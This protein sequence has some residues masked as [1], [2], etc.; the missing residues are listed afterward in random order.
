MILEFISTA[1]ETQPGLVELFLDLSS[2]EDQVSFLVTSYEKQT[3]NEIIKT[4]QKKC[5]FSQNRS[6]VSKDGGLVL[7]TACDM[8]SVHCLMQILT[9]FFFIFWCLLVS[10]YVSFN[11]Y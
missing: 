7:P 3:N 1:V 6:A 2:K 8:S 4:S 11:L 9:A 5:V 10:V